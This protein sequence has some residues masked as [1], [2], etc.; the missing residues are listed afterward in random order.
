M[1]SLFRTLFLIFLFVSLI[2]LL[3]FDVNAQDDQY[4]NVSFS[5]KIC[6][7]RLILFEP[8]CVEASLTNSS[9]KSVRI[10]GD[11]KR[12]VACEYREINE[13]SWKTLRN[14]WLPKATQPPLPPEELE[15]DK[16]VSIHLWFYT[17]DNGLK[18]VFKSGQKY[19]IRLLLTSRNPI[20]SLL[21]PDTEIV[22]SDVPE[23]EQEAFKLLL[24]DVGEP[25]WKR[26]LFDLLPDVQSPQ[27]SKRIEEYVKVFPNS[28]FSIYFRRT[29]IAIIKDQPAGSAQNELC[30]SY[31]EYLKNHASWVLSN[32]SL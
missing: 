18:P 10:P 25:F 13:I 30:R 2:M 28:R 3:F 31:L 23:N 27:S 24:P 17:F 29:Y 6:R 26:Q 12:Y 4:R 19:E 5:H 20:I 15:T 21:S 16:S 11:W 14:W 9:K 1:K 8:L 32:D 7:S 22:V